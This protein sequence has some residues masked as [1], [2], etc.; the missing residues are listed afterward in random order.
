MSLACGS[1]P[2]HAVV[3]AG[4][5]ALGLSSASLVMTVATPLGLK[6]SAVPGCNAAAARRQGLGIGG[7]NA[8]PPP[9][10][11]PC[12]WA[13]RSPGITTALCSILHR[14]SLGH[15]LQEVEIL[16]PRRPLAAFALERR[17]RGSAML[18]QRVR[19]HHA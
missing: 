4:F 1:M 15:V 3:F 11:L 9:H 8:V 13:A 16:P 10:V 17:Q 14:V 12:G 7:A 2:R 6:P 5:T 19:H 18:L